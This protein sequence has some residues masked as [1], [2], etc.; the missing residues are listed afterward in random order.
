MF[1]IIF[2][3]WF[4]VAVLPFLI[5]QEGNSMLIAFLKKRGIY[6]DIWY[7][8]LFILLTFFTILLIGV[9]T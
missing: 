3:I 9:A 7:S 4:L 8:L 5:F 6:W 1:D 2:K